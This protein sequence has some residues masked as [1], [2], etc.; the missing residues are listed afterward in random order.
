M[1]HVVLASFG[2]V[3]CLALAGCPGQAGERGGNDAPPKDGTPAAPDRGSTG[4]NG[5]AAE[6]HG[7]GAQ[8]GAASP[9]ECYDRMES[10][11][12]G[13]NFAA[14]Y[15]LLCAESQ[16]D[17]LPMM[18]LLAGAVASGDEVSMNEFKGIL[19]RHGIEEL[20]ADEPTGGTG[21]AP[22]SA[23]LFK[24]VKDRRGLFGDVM[25]FALSRQG[26][27]DEETVG[28]ENLVV[29]G[30]TATGEIVKKIGPQA[31]LEREPV[32]FKRVDGRW[33]ADIETGQ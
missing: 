20:A 32:R 23:E 15:D 12:K 11:F 19:T 26:N 13:K 31:K 17:L 8:R 25:A 28:L 7:P 1:R 2:A 5:G 18:T 27:E 24:D 3:L 30:D 29:K 4:A 6:F 16:D 14:Y 10:A 21:P 22:A 9:Q 33:F